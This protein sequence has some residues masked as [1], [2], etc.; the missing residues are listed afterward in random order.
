MNSLQSASIYPLIYLLSA[1]LSF[2]SLH[3]LS[4]KCPFTVSHTQPLLLSSNYLQI[5]CKVAMDC[6]CVI[7]LNSP[8]RLGL[9][10]VHCVHQSYVH[11]ERVPFNV[12]LQSDWSDVL[13]Q[14]SIHKHHRSALWGWG[15]P[16]FSFLLLFPLWR[17]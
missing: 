12:R 7:L 3:N 9:V 17:Q 14:V 16:P 15:R 6:L 1:C 10:T 2:L 8:G 4:P 13:L 11:V 5:I